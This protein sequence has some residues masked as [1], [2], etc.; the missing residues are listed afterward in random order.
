ME[1]YQRIKKLRKNILDLSQE[2]FGKAINISRSNEANIETGRINVTERVITDICKSF[3]VSE[4]WL[5]TGEGEIFIDLERDEAIAAWAAKITRTDFDNSFVPKFAEML[6]KLDE[7]D[8]K[9][10]EKM[11]KFLYEGQQKKD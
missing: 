11:A 5:R 2:T 6:T 3:N 9:T 4:L 1:I 8:W 7:N 10:L